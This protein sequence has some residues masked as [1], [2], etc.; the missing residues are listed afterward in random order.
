MEQHNFESCQNDYGYGE[1]AVIGKKFDN[2][3][4]TINKLINEVYLSKVR[5]RETEFEVLRSQINPHFLYNALQLV[6]A[7]AVFCGNN[8]ISQL[9]T[10]LGYLLDAMNNKRTWL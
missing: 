4:D 8:E 2:M 5:Q 1:I 6:K 3:V 10:S 7:E 9:V